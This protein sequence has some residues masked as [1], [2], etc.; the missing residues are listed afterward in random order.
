MVI[1][2]SE[3][4]V[5]YAQKVCNLLNNSE[6]RTSVDER[7]EKIGRKIRE[8]ELKK[9]PYMLIVGDKE[10]EEGQ[11]SVRRHKEGDLGSMSSEAFAQRVKEEIAS[12]L[13][14]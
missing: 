4:H 6:I 2:V 13:K 9:V 10:E 5:N 1:P 3:K 12:E 14:S 11:I 8:A 7:N